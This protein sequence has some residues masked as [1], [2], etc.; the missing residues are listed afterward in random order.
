MKR[1]RIGGKYAS[2][3]QREFYSD[4]RKEKI[5]LTI[6]FAEIIGDKLLQ[7]ANEGVIEKQIEESIETVITK[8]VKDACESYSLKKEIENKI[9]KEVSDAVNKI[10]FTGYNQY[11]VDTFNSMVKSM[12]VDDVRKKISDTFNQLFIKKV[13]RIKM[14]EIAKMYR[15]MMLEMDDGEKYEYD[16]NFF[17]SFDEDDNYDDFRWITITF[18]LEEQKKDYLSRYRSGSNT[19]KLVM[20]IHNYKDGDFEISSI[21]YED[22]DL[23][24]LNELRYMSNF[25]CFMASLYFNKTKI[26]LD[27]EEDDIETDLGLDI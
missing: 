11:I 16:N 27:V 2:L 26:E 4:S 18:A 19:D 24:K 12:L 15:D 14:S 3:K 22:K 21:S 8:A 25:E 9:E 20:R 7:M 5:K 23:S 10:G 1:K 6:D 13:D 17:V